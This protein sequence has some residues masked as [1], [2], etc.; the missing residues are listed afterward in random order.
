MQ[1]ILTHA[2]SGTGQSI[3][4]ELRDSIETLRQCVYLCFPRVIRRSQLSIE[5]SQVILVIW[6]RSSERTLFVRARA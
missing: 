6:N 2:H 5:S 3:S 4:H 1:S